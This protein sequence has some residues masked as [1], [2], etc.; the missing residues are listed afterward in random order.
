[1][2]IVDLGE[3]RT[4]KVK[5]TRGMKKM[6]RQELSTLLETKALVPEGKSYNS[7]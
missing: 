4:S 5:I 2:Y 6:G 3:T 7:I 1:V